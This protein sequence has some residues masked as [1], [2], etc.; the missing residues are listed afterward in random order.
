MDVTPVVEGGRYPAKAVGRRGLPGHAPRSSARAT[1]RSNADVVLTGPDGVRRPPVRMTQG[2]RGEPDLLARRRSPPDERRRLDLRGRGLERPGRHLAARRRDQDPGRHRRRADVRRGR[3]AARAG[4][5]R[6]CPKRSAG[7]P[8]ARR[9]RSRALRDTGPPGAGPATRP[10]SPPRSTRCSPRHPLRDLVTTEG[11]LPVLRR[12]RAGAV[13]L[14]VRVLPALRGRDVDEAT[15]TVVVRAPSRTAAEA[16]RRRRR[17]GLRRRLPAADP[18]DRHGSTARARNNTLDPGPDDPGS[19]WAIGSRRGRPRRDPPRPRHDRRLRRVRRR[20][21]RELGLE[22]ALDLALQAAPDH[23]WVDRAPGVVHHPRR[24]HHRLRREPAE[25]VPGHLPDQ[26][27]QRPAR[28]STPRCCAIVRHWMSHGVR[29]F[30]VDNPH[31]KPVEFWEWLL[32]E[33]RTTDPDVLFL[34]EAFTRPAMMRALGKVGFHQSYTYFTWRNAKWE[35]EEYLT[36]LAHETSHVHAAELLREHPRHPARLPAVRRPGGV[37][38]PRRA[39]RDRLAD[40]G[41]LRRLRAV[42]ARRGAARQRGVPRL[43]EVPDPAP[44]LGRR[45]GR[46]A[47]PGAVPHPAQRDP[48]RAPGPAAA[49][50]PDRPPHRRRRDRSCYSASRDAATDDTVIVVVNVDPHGDPRDHRAPRHAG[51]RP[52]LARHVRR[53][54]TRSPA[55]PGAGASTTTSASTRTT[56]PPTS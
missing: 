55:R 9:T 47:H 10:R 11:P 19:P 44:R 22:V 12:P 39:R 36:E 43:R 32:G 20:A 37:Q 29:I 7:P 50:Q 31:T 40:L 5:R 38:D 45:R 34:A 49:A 18:P 52:G 42:R 13:R 27:R 17:D 26:L 56:S 24:R 3:A 25:E 1:T 4:R 23:P 15:G 2:R 41:R 54:T 14:L 46:G 28:A 6:R 8:D 33:V 16:A 48:P 53:C 21:P 35:L 30:R 51:A